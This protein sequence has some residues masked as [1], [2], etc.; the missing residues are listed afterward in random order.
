MIAPCATW[1]VVLVTEK[2]PRSQESK[3][4]AGPRDPAA[5]AKN[6]ACVSCTC[7]KVDC[8]LH[9]VV[10][11]ILAQV[12]ALPECRDHVPVS[13]CDLLVSGVARVQFPHKLHGRLA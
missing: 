2:E 11:M 3:G 1:S 9:T 10:A 13:L 5:V 6:R 8:E 12:A 4:R 7:E